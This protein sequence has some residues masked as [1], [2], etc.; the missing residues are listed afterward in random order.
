MFCGCYAIVKKTDLGCE[1]AY[2]VSFCA[3]SY[4]GSSQPSKGRANSRSPVT[5]AEFDWLKLAPNFNG[6][7]IRCSAGFSPDGHFEP[8]EELGDGWVMLGGDFFAL[9][10]RKL[11]EGEKKKEKETDKKD[12]HESFRRITLKQYKFNIYSAMLRIFCTNLKSDSHVST[13]ESTINSKHNFP[14]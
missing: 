7:V 1:L 6:H 8:Q 5:I 14:L 10:T 11:K 2:S 9:N 4:P 3:T 12:S 13:T